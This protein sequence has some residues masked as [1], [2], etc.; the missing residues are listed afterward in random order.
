MWV[1]G[2][3]LAACVSWA[4]AVSAQPTL[5]LRDFVVMPMTGSVD[6]Q[7]S[8]D[9]LLSRV[10]ALRE[11]IG[12]ANRLFISDLNGPLYILD[13]DARKFTVYLDFNG[14]EGK[15]GIFRKLATKVGYGNGLNGFY[16]DPDYTR[17]GKF[18]TV[19]IEDP[20][21]PGP[22]LPDSSKFPALNV[23]GYT[24]T[25]AITTPGP[26][27]HEGVLVEWTDSNPSNATFEG[28]AREL[29]RVQLNTTSHP[30]GD[31]IFN[32]AAGRGDPDWRVLYLECGDGASG[33]STN[34]AIR[35][36]PP[37]LDNLE[38]K[39]L[40]IVP[41]LNE[42]VATSTV[43]PNG[44][45]RIPNDNPFVSTP[46]ARKEIWAYGFRNPHRLAWAVDPANPSNNRLIANSVGLHTWETVYLVRK[47]ANYGYGER[48]G[49]EL[50]EADNTTAPLPAVDKIPVRI[51]EAATDTMVAPTYPVIQ[52]G[53]GPNGGDSIG[54]GFVYN[55]KAIPALRGKYV[56]TDLTTGRIWYADYKD[57]LA[58][59]DGKP[60][61]MAAIHE[62]NV[63]WNDPNDSPDAG[64]KI[65][66][67]MFSIIEAA[68]HARGGKSPH[69][70][71]R[72]ELI[73]RGRADVR[74]SIDANGELY[75]YSKGDG[76]IRAVVEAIGF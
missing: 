44:R 65:Y 26:T 67:S 27:K 47:G 11:E 25:D 41:D 24:T 62:V 75:L 21:L 19:H 43:S 3:G 57:M 52:Y 48:E 40:R 13:K 33:E 53:H 60:G 55:G 7:G 18:Y 71:G 4:P 51:G 29:L 45:Y 56:F 73:K 6:G 22:T 20:A 16:L 58:A 5:E 76:V 30:L 8:N 35:S 54:S 31:L 74:F 10:N 1:A 17:N 66:E 64:K 68:Y 59:D 12:G 46:G 50:L 38:G 70:P 2:L 37:R 14:S 39:I 23:T 34:V 61:T 28:T 9:V 69:L 36:N 72:A 32:P 63:L 42:H 49:N 15:G